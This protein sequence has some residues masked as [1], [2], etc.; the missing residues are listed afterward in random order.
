MFLVLMFSPKE[1]TS[2][3]LT[4]KESRLPPFLE[5]YGIRHCPDEHHRVKATLFTMLDPG[6]FFRS[7]SWEPN[8]Q[9]TGIQAIC[10]GHLGLSQLEHSSQTV[11]KYQL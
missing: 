7:S 2:P 4:K 5:L 11:S 3:L 8:L 6:L 10:R 1:E 9:C